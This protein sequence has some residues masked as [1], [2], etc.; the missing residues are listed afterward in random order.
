MED[1]LERAKRREEEEKGR[2]TRE[3]V[4]RFVASKEV[5]AKFD[6][7]VAV[8]EGEGGDRQTEEGNVR[9]CDRCGTE[10]V[11]KGELEEVSLVCALNCYLARS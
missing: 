3:K 6:Y 10:F 5:L 7:V 11:V 1:E 2:L 9:K 8:P 4:E